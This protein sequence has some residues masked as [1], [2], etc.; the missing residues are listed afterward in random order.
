MKSKALNFKLG[1]SLV[2]AGLFFGIINHILLEH[3]DFTIKLLI[4]YPIFLCWGI[5][6][7]FFPGAKTDSLKT[8]NDMKDFWN[9]SPKLHKLV[10]ILSLLCGAV[11]SGTIMLFYGVS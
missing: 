8:T 1:L 7:L 6:L 3:F 5:G 10:W 9:R 4:G 2:I 11:G